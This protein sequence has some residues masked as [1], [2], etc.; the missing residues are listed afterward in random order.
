MIVTGRGR[1]FARCAR[2]APALGVGQTNL[3]E[4]HERIA[5]GP[6]MGWIAVLVRKTCTLIA[7]VCVAACFAQAASA[8][9]LNTVTA[10]PAKSQ[11]KPDWAGFYFKSNSGTSDPWTALTP[12]TGFTSPTAAAPPTSE[13][14]GYNFQS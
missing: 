14:F 8:L 1:G 6:R 10:P 4:S 7:V 3:L 5:E 9:D 13:A 11:Q 12:A 2:C